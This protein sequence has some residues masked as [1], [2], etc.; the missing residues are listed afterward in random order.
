MPRRYLVLASAFFVCVLMALLFTVSPG[1]FTVSAFQP[2]PTPPPQ[3]PQSSFEQRAA[4]MLADRLPVEKLAPLA[5]QPC[6]NNMAGIYPC[7]NIDLLAFLPLSQLGGGNASSSWG[8]TDPDTQKEYAL[9]GR[10][11]GTSFVDITNP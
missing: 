4:H 3:G 9:L 6:V 1:Q 11:T 10:S 2:T 8:W 5:N 7:S